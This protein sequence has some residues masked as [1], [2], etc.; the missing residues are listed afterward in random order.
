[1][2]QPTQNNRDNNTYMINVNLRKSNVKSYLK[3]Y[4]D[5]NFFILKYTYP[6]YSFKK[7]IIFFF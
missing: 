2:R 6:H 1:M 7:L 5:F 3:F 4:F